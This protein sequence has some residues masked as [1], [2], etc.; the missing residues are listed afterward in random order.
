MPGGS[1]SHA[2]QLTRPGQWPILTG[3]FLL[4]VMLVSP[5]AAGGGCWLNAASL[6]VLACSWLV[7]VVMLNGG[8]LAFNSAYD[9]DTGAVAYLPDPPDPPAGLGP[10][11]AV[12]MASGALLGWLVIGPGFGL[13]VAVCVVLS[14][15][16]SHPLVRLKSRPGLDLATNMVGYGAGTTL[17]GILAGTAAYLGLPPGTCATEPGS[18]FSLPAVDLPALSGGAGQQLSQALAGSKGWLVAGF[19]LLFG[20]FYPATQIYQIGQDLQ[21]GDRTLTTSLGPRRSLV[22]A[23]LLGLAAGAAFVLAWQGSW[24]HWSV[25]LPVLASALWLG[26]FLRWLGRQGGM[27]EAAHERSM[28]RALTLWAVVDIGVLLG[29]FLK[30]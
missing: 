27:D 5:R 18:L 19:G 16:Y 23:V 29:W 10:A 4:A 2:W 20:S 1:W 13:I 9:R 26:H 11:A 28:Y 30:P 24:N 22:L 21:R 14:V 6:L 15:L 3:Q 12:F 8:T 7:W 25:L 17:A